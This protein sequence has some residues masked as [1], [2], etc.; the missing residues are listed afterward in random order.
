VG[1][2]TSFRVYLPRI[3]G[4]P[5]PERKEA[6]ASTETGSE[7]ILLVEDQPAVRSF[8]SAALQR[9]GYRVIEACGGEEAITVAEGHP[10]RI[11]LLLTDVVVPGMNGK[12]LS[13]RL[14][15]LRPDMKVLFTSGY[16]ADVIAHRGVLDHGLSFLHKPYSL[17]ELA[18]KVRQLLG[19]ASDPGVEA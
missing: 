7:T 17:D 14:K 4:R 16:T 9:Y 11:H 12:E 1:A 8:T 18:A 6:G 15:A 19:E 10:G 13:E 3:D 2:G 5:L